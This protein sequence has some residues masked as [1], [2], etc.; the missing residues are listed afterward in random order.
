MAGLPCVS[1]SKSIYNECTQPLGV[2]GWP[3]SPRYLPDWICEL[4]NANATEVFRVWT[5]VTDMVED[6]ISKHIAAFHRR[7]EG[8]LFLQKCTAK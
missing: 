7:V 6:K 3:Q 5:N 2:C 1:D 4:C 8:S